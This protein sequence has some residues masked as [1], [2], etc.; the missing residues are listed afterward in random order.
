VDGQ[1]ILNNF[2]QVRDAAIEGLG[3]AHIPEDLARPYLSQG[4]LVW[5]LE[6]LAAF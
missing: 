3:L 6:L 2:F 5:V 4:H 1:V